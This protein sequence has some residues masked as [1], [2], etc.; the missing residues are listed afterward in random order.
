MLDRN[1]LHDTPAGRV[2][3]CVAFAVIAAAVLMA[4]PH[5]LVA[6]S[7]DPAGQAAHKETGDH[8]WAPFVSEHGKQSRRTFIANC[9]SPLD[10]EEADL[11]QQWRTAEATEEA[12]ALADRQFYWNVAQAVG[13]LLATIFTALA[14]LAAAAA[15]QTSRRTI[16]HMED[17]SKREL[18]AYVGLEKIDF[19]ILSK[20]NGYVPIAIG[21]PS[22]LFKDFISVTIKNFGA[23]PAYDVVVLCGGLST[24]FLGRAPVGH[25][26][27][28]AIH[29]NRAPGNFLTRM[30]LSPAQP[31]V[32]KCPL[33][34]ALPF[35]QSQQRERSMFVYGRIYYRDAYGNPWSTKFCF[36]WEPWHPGGARFVPYEEFNG[37]DQ[38]E[39]P[40]A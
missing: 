18:R 20:R 3:F 33:Y 4:I 30:L 6:S 2:A 19:E 31:E 29:E 5:L 40:A 27:D 10:R 38:A 37:E 24:A 25:N 9:T 16:E 1:W 21:A 28:R 23:T 7:E 11:C 35:W 22:I 34:N 26:F 17:T 39:A 12:S 8:H 36:V 13:T 15:V 14:A 32:I